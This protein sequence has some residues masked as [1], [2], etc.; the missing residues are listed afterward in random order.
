MKDA[1]DESLYSASREVF[2]D[3]EKGGDYAEL[4]NSAVSK[5]YGVELSQWD[6]AM[7]VQRNGFLITDTDGVVSGFQS[8]IAVHSFWRSYSYA[9]ACVNIIV[10]KVYLICSSSDLQEPPTHTLADLAFLPEITTPNLAELIARVHE[11]AVARVGIEKANSLRKNLLAVRLV[12]H[13]LAHGI[14]AT[15]GT[16]AIP[17]LWLKPHK[18]SE[19]VEAF[20]G[21]Q[22][23]QNTGIVVSPLTTNK[24]VRLD[25][26]DS[27]LRFVTYL[28]VSCITDLMPM[29]ADAGW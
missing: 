18:F 14:H 7:G 12:R 6:F 5:L 11:L 19:Y 21:Y 8:R 1:S 15:S 23:Y 25:I 16:H 9:W 10:Q 3:V 27:F 2:A 22:V 20:G 28:N 26:H 17:S 29:L 24:K 4:H 13:I